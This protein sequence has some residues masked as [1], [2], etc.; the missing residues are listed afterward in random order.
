M[1]VNAAPLFCLTVDREQYQNTTR[2]DCQTFKGLS[3]ARLLP[4][5]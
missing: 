2:T 5:Y 4:E 3:A 1:A